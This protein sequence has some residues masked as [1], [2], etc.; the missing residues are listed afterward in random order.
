MI[1]Y[2]LLAGYLKKRKGNMEDQLKEVIRETGFKK[3]EQFI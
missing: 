1:F 2:L 3:F